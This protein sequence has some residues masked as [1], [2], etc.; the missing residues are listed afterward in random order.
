MNKIKR[1]RI[2]RREHNGMY[3]DTPVHKADTTKECY[4][5]LLTQNTDENS[6]S[7]ECLVDD[8]QINDTEFMEAFKSGECPGDLQFF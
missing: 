5:F 1:F 8:I 3:D 4:D 6:F 7:I 2:I